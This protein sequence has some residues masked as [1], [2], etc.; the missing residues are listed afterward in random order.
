MA[1]ASINDQLVFRVDTVAGESSVTITI[2]RACTIQFVS[3]WGTAD[4]ESAFVVGTRIRTGSPNQVVINDFSLPGS[5]SSGP[6]QYTDVAVFS[7]NL[8][9]AGV[10]LLEGDQL[11][12]VKD[13]PL[14]S[15]S[16]FISVSAP[17]AGV[18][19][20]AIV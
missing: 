13:N 14:A 15:G 10:D 16:I 4:A 2:P 3:A 9:I 11:L 20:T 8:Y 12:L 6:T 5:V 17:G 7:K 1:T 18:K 19:A